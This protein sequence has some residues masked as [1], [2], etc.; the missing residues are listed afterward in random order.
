MA[1]NEQAFNNFLKTNESVKSKSEKKIFDNPDINILIHDGNLV[2]VDPAQIKL[3]EFKDRPEK[4]LGNL[5]AF[6]EDLIKI[7]QQQPCIVRLSND[8]KYTY[9]LIIGERRWRACQ[10]AGLKL[11]C[12]ITSLDD[13][14]AALAQATE[15]LQRKNLSDYAKGI[16]YYRLIE[17]KILTREDIEEKL[18]INK[19]QVSRLLSF[20]RLKKDFKEIYD[21]ILDFSYISAR[22][23]SEMCALA[24][25]GENYIQAIISTSPLLKSG[26]I[27]ARTLKAEIERIIN[28][29]HS[30]LGFEKIFNSNGQ[31]IF[32]WRIDGNKNTSI[33][34]TRNFSKNINKEEINKFLSNLLNLDQNATQGDS[35]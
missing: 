1:I 24:T 4:E 19:M 11:K 18:S 15:N 20:G 35:L 27:G 28:S 9:E 25:K 14:T 7:G 16:N 10:I 3:W 12:I 33:S 23:C 22:T 17:K 21:S 29:Y 2:E 6:A 13:Y 32:S 8:S 31:H 26:K 34:F 30:D 5:K